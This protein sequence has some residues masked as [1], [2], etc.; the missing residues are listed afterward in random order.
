M[1]N[2]PALLVGAGVVVEGDSSVAINGLAQIGQAVAITADPNEVVDVDVTGGLFIANGG[3]D[4]I[5]SSTSIDITAAPAIA[6][7]QIWPAIG[8]GSSRRWG[9]AG[10]AFFRSVERR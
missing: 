4:G 1:K 7:I 2:Y 5:S 3:I 9:P 8:P 6:S 10:G